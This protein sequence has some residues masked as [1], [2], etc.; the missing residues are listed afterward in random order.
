MKHYISSHSRIFFSN[1]VQIAGRPWSLF[2]LTG[3]SLHLTL[4]LLDC[5]HTAAAAADTGAIWSRAWAD[6]DHFACREEEEKGGGGGGREQKKRGREKKKPHFK[7]LDLLQIEWALHFTSEEFSCC[8]LLQLA[9]RYANAKTHWEAFP[10]CLACL[11]VGE[12]SKSSDLVDA[13]KGLQVINF[14]V[15]SLTVPRSK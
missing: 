3:P 6:F 5:R 1:S 15:L 12:F 11:N 10:A 7:L 13:P 9:T 4:E 2:L 8:C 14:G